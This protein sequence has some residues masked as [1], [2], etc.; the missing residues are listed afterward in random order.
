[1]TRRGS[2][3]VR[4]GCYTCKIRKVKCDE[5]KPACVKCTS[6]GRTCDGYPSRTPASYS[7]SEL[8]S[9]TAVIPSPSTGRTSREGRALDFFRHVVAPSLSGY[10]D[11]DFWTRL[12]PEALQEEPAIRHAVVAISSIYEV[13]GNQRLAL[14]DSADGRFALGHYNRALSL[15]TSAESDSRGM[16]FLCILFVCIESLQNNVQ[17]VA[18]HCRHGVKILNSVDITPWV[19]EHLLPLF[20]RF[21]IFPYFFG[22]GTA[23][24][25]GLQGLTTTVQGPFMTIGDSLAVLDRLVAR[26]I[27]FIRSTDDFRLIGGRYRE[28]FPDDASVEY[29]ELSRAINSWLQAFADL[30]AIR[31]PTNNE[32]IQ[33]YA[34]AH[35]KALVAKIWV[36]CSLDKSEMSYDYHL[37]SFRAIV[38]AAKDVIASLAPGEAL[39]SRTKFSFDMG[40]LPLLYVVIVRCRTLEVR[41]E[42]LAALGKLGIR[43]ESLFESTA[44]HGVGK[45]VIELEHGIDLDAFDRGELPE[46]TSFFVPDEMRVRDPL[47]TRETKAQLDIQGRL[48]LYMKIWFLYSNL[49]E[50]L[51]NEEWV[52]L[53]AVHDAAPSPSPSGNSLDE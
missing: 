36:E 40:Y 8:L 33:A 16:L 14:L 9:A 37:P 2:Q 47:M 1:M 28:A 39:S 15:L 32:E 4:T 30:K 51:M 23:E 7:W 10:V 46:A 18:E 48:M 29:A 34:T 12:V 31:P 5:T 24:F 17:G 20:V 26:A 22:H 11:R 41:R 13:L 42:A 25:P 52:E 27:H 44:M 53:C 3:K 49:G 21:S 43:Y 38:K 45:R 19:R 35:M 50:P 6:T